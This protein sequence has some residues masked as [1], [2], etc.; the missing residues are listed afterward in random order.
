MICVEIIQNIEDYY[1]PIVASQGG[2]LVIEKRWDDP[3][4]NA[5]AQQSGRIWKVTMFGG[6][7]RRPEVTADGFAISFEHDYADNL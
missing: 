7:A 5:Y 3:T 2:R 1:A 4:V 6:L